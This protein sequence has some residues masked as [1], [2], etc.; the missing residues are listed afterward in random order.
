MAR[1]KQKIKC[2]CV[3]CT[4]LISKRTSSIKC[5]QCNNLFHIRCTKITHKM[6]KKEAANKTEFAFVCD[7]CKLCKCGHCNAPV[8][9]NQNHITCNNSECSLKYHLKCTNIS[10]KA[11]NLKKT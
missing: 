11:Y 2:V 10:L 1:S 3:K 5:D 6:L 7:F 4:E 8:F 9:N